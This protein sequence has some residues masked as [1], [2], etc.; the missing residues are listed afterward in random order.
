MALPKPEGP[1]WVHVYKGRDEAWADA[2]KIKDGVF[3]ID[4]IE[5]QIAGIPIEFEFY[6]RRKKDEA[7]TRRVWD[8]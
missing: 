1:G 5:Y 7:T 6:I 2:K 8:A 3:M 4:G